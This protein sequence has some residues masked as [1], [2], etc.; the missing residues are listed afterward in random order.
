MSNFLSREERIELA[1]P[2]ITRLENFPTKTGTTINL[3]AMEYPA[4][5]RLREIFTRYIEQTGGMSGEYGKISFPEMGR[6][7]EYLLPIRRGVKP[8]F[9]LK[10]VL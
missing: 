6:K 2:I 8:L 3:Y 9:V 5:R 1:R 10:N 7:I 4:T